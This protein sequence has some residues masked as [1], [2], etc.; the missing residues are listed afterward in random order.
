M[1]TPTNA[2][3]P[4]GLDGQKFPISDVIIPLRWAE[5]PGKE[6]IWMEFGG[7]PLRLR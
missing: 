5:G 2:S 7:S 1:H 6:G 3:T 4:L